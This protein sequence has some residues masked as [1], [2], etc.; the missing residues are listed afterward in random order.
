MLARSSREAEPRISS[1]AGLGGL[2]GSAASARAMSTALAAEKASDGGAAAALAG[3]DWAPRRDAVRPAAGMAAPPS[4][5]R[6]SSRRFTDG[7][8]VVLVPAALSA[9]SHG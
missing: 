4:A 6:S 1:G 5:S 9:H 2:W 7:G 3:V 8:M